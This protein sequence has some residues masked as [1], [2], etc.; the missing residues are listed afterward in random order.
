M[1]AGEKGDAQTTL[2]DGSEMT[3]RAAPALRTE[4]SAADPAAL[5]E[6]VVMFD[7]EAAQGGQIM[8]WR[9][10]GNVRFGVR[11]LGLSDSRA[12]RSAASG[13]G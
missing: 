2:A 4:R 7:I 9:F 6:I 1:R 12:C 11:A 8:C 5:E 3:A 10:H 13:P